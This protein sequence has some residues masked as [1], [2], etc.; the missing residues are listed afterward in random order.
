[1]TLRRLTLA[2]LPGNAGILPA[3][4]SQRPPILRR[5]ALAP[6][7]LL[8]AAGPAAGGDTDRDCRGLFALTDLDH[9]VEPGFRVPAS[10]GVPAHCRVR[11]VVNRAIRFEVTLPDDWNGRMMFS[12]VGGAAGFIGDTT[13]LLGRGF[14]MA[15]TDT[16]HE[17]S[18][19]DYMRQPEALLDY[20]YRGVHLATAAA[21]RVIQTYYGREIDHSYL[22]GCSNGGRAAMLEATRF[23]DDYDGILAGAPAFRFQEFVPWMM[24]GARLQAKHPLT[25]E[26]FQL[27]GKASREA[28]DALDG[29][30]DGV[31]DDPMK[32]TADVFDLN[33][34][35]C[36]PDS[37]ENCLTA[38]QLQTARY[39]YEDVVDA[40]G[41]VLS[42]GVPPGAEDAGDWA[43]WVLPSALGG[44]QSLIGGMDMLLE[45]LMRFE[46]DF[47][48]ESFDPVADR[49]LLAAAT[50][51]LDVLT[52]DLSAFR[53]RGG[54][55]LMYQGW[56]D[57]PLRPQRA[58][59]Y[60]HDVEKETGGAEEAADFYR[61]FMVPGMIHCA[62]GPGAWFTD[63]VA[64]LVAWTE[65]GVAPARIEASRPGPAPEFTRP[66]CAY[67]EAAKYN[68]EGD[69]NDGANWSCR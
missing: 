23:P 35:Q 54:K 46:P 47:D 63:Y 68:G 30:E 66:L 58:I 3:S 53:E 25:Q 59:D 27:L 16:G 10:E 15:S 38:G 37:T 60:L 40:D 4:G 49:D 44:D 22:K 6:L 57:Y 12:T 48:V 2:V 14:A 43:M 20:A 1:M 8:A 7:L 5:L 41:N 9:A 61:M 62:R 29:V 11:G 69:V 13:S 45:A 51:P 50:A 33:A 64:P 65:Q 56:N 39:M 55:L 28:C 32:C 31:I 67:P 17:G 52:A 19:R 34:L 18:D 36:P 26:S 21:K 42:P 24:G